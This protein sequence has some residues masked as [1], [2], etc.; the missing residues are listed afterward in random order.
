MLQTELLGAFIGLLSAF[1]FAVR[2]PLVRKATVTGSAIDALTSTL[3]I[4]VLVY[5]FLS[6]VLNYPNFGITTFSFFAFFSAGLCGP[7]FGLFCL[8]EGTNRIGASITAPMTRGS[9]LISVLIAILFLEESITIMHVIGIIILLIG[10][11]I[12]SR[13]ISNGNPKHSPKRTLDFLFP[14]GVILSFGLAIP[15][16]KLGYSAGTPVPVGLTIA[17]STALVSAI[18]FSFFDK[19]NPLRSFQ[20]NE[21]NLYIFAGFAHALAM[22]LLNLGLS[23]YPIV[24]IQPFRSMT[25]LF[26]LL[27]S[28]FFI[29]KLERIN[30]WITLGTIFTVIGGIL[31]AMCM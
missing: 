8:Y 13:E 1:F 21:W 14:V 20:S 17:F 18:L 10:V 3:V 24:I 19:R 5:F 15:L 9:L 2:F 29:K 23:I 31:I 30:K 4:D 28:Y 6:V 26:V 27:L 11:M 22:G 12:I 7:F 25:P 16:L